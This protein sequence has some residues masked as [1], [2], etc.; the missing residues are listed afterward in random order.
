MEAL[1]GTLVTFLLDRSGSMGAVRDSTIEAFNGY[2]DGLQS[3]PEGIDFT[4][5]LFDTESLDKICVAMPVAR[6]TPLSRETYVP[7][8]GTPLIDAAYKTIKAVEMAVAADGSNPKV[9]I[10]IQTDGEENQSTEHT[11]EALRALVRDK[12]DAGWQFNFMGAGIDAYAE[13]ARLGISAFATMSYNH[14]DRGATRRAFAAAGSNTQSFAHGRT[15][16]TSFSSAQRAAAGDRFV[17]PDL[18]AMQP[19]TG[20]APLDLTK[21]STAGTSHARRKTVDDFSL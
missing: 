6:V 10:C 1:M 19:T 3:E 13:G 11:W 5:L 4:L 17:P 8:G 18:A 7:R 21:P 16:N 12:T 15:V 9:V 2:L 14:R 20:P